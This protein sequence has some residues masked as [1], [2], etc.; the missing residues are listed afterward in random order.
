MFRFSV[1]SCGVFDAPLLVLSQ[2][3]DWTTE[4]HAVSL[5]MF[6]IVLG[7]IIFDGQKYNQALFQLTFPLRV[8]ELRHTLTTHTRPLRAD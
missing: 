3:N 1:N 5:I 7:Q 2:L 8:L 4:R 6:Y